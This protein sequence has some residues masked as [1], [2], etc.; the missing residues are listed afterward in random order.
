MTGYAFLEGRILPLAEAKLGVMT[1]ALHYGTGCFEGIRGNWN[2]EAKRMYLFRVKDHYER[3]SQSCRIMR[4]NLAYSVEELCRLTLELVEKNGCQEDV[5]I[6][7]LAYKSSQTVGVRLHNLEDDLLIFVTPF[8]AYLDIDKGARC[9]VSSWRRIDD[10]MIPPRAKVSGLYANSALAKTEAWERGFDE[11]IMLTQDG[12]VSEGS[13]ENIFLVMRGK[14][15]T[16]PPSDNI[17]VGITRDSVITLA[18]EELGMETVER[19]IGR[20]ELYV[21]EECFMTGT[22]AHVTPVVDIDGRKVGDGK[23]G[24]LTRKLQRLYFDVVKG[25]NPKYLNWCTPVR[26]PAAQVP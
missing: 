4:I 15:I 12:H 5:Y 18:R 7:P 16:P 1:H 9:C 19:S 8:G 10:N 22:A 17:L 23:V 24:E 26:C 25:K 6:R 2:S 20:T 13:G 3:L 21:A 14:L 11:A